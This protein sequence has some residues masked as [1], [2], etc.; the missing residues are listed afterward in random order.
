[1]SDKH[2]LAF[3]KSSLIFFIVFIG[4]ILFFSAVNF[5][6]AAEL[7]NPLGDDMNDPRIFIGRLIKGILGL[8]GSIALLMFIYG[9]VVYLTAQGENE[10]IQRAKSTLTWATVG[11]AVIFGSYAFLNYL[12]AGLKG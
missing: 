11:L 5:A 10:R 4:V 2:K 7:K 8:S 12:F 6:F 3:F 1:M 9:G